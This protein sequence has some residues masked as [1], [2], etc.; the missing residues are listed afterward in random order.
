MKMS[1]HG[2]GGV[3][4]GW[5][6]WKRRNRANKVCFMLSVALAAIVTGSYV[7]AVT[8]PAPGDFARYIVF[9]WIWGLCAIGLIFGMAEYRTSPLRKNREPGHLVILLYLGALLIVTRML[10]MVLFHG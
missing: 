9:N 4:T 2:I 7:W 6:A 10:N 3:L 5:L 8:H 1:F